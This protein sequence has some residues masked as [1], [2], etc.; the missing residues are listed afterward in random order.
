MVWS[1][2]RIIVDDAGVEMSTRVESDSRVR[3]G[4]ASRQ[5]TVSS[6]VDRSRQVAFVWSST[7][8]S[9]SRAYPDTSTCV[10]VDATHGRGWD[11]ML[12]L[13]AT[14]RLDD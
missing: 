14:P 2:A 9:G 6:T 5:S 3:L 13:D 12:D 1:V 11:R 10:G 8:R 4:T 7:A